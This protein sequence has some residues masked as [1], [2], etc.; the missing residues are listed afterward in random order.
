MKRRKLVTV[1]LSVLFI[2]WTGLFIWQLIQ[3]Q[4]GNR[5]YLHADELSGISSTSSPVPSPSPSPDSE[6]PLPV[7]PPVVQKLLAIELESLQ[8][9]NSDV[10]GWISIPDT[11]ISYPIVQSSDNSYYLDHTWD[12][13]WN[14][15]GSI[16]LDWHIQSDF[17]DFNTVIYGHRMRNTSMFGSLKYYRD[18]DYWASH[19]DVY[20]FNGSSVSR[21]QIFAAY[22]VSVLG[23]TYRMS[24]SDSESRQTFLDFCVSQSV[25]KTD[26]TPTIGDQV[27]TLSTCTGTGHANRW[28]VQAVLSET[29]PSL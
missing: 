5:S 21:Y 14:P 17:S 1:L 28:V 25:L 10:L 23:D 15:A 12:K 29:Y 9:V 26:I 24:F 20:I 22:E 18:H 4:R 11:E 7:Y 2:F 16:F 3:Y 27:I 8:E 13:S 6:D 19:P